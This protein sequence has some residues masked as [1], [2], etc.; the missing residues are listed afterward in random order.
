M[1]RYA[2]ALLAMALLCYINARYPNLRCE[3]FIIGS[4]GH[5]LWAIMQERCR[6]QVLTLCTEE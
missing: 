4:H 2:L 6:K 3:L 1:P 5:F